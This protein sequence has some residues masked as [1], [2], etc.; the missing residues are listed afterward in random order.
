MVTLFFSGLPGSHQQKRP[1]QPLKKPE[2]APKKPNTQYVHNDTFKTPRPNALLKGI[3]YIFYLCIKRIKL[4]PLIDFSN[5]L[6]LLKSNLKLQT[7]V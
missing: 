2:K 7:Y 5:L 4:T 6:A 1:D 3:I